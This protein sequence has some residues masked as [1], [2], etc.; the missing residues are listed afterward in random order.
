MYNI[1]NLVGS[2][3]AIY[4]LSRQIVNV[5]PVLSQGH[6]SRYELVC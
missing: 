1:Q 6:Y 2:S 4:I 5:G 3:H